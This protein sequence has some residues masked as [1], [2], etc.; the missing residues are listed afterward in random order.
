M[1]DQASGSEGGQPAVSA[2]DTVNPSE[3]PRT[4]SPIVRG[5]SLNRRFGASDS[6]S[7]G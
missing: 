7:F 2:K 1:D 6:S 5:L 4:E 3:R